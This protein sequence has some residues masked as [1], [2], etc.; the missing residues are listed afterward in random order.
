M[1]SIFMENLLR[2]KFKILMEGIENGAV[3]NPGQR[4]PMPS[5]FQRCNE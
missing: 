5:R 4:V 1:A 2:V 3:R